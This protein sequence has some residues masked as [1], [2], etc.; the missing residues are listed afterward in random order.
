MTLATALNWYWILKGLAYIGEARVKE[1][2]A[3]A[4]PTPRFLLA[5]AHH[6][7][8]NYLLFQ[9][10]HAESEIWFK[11]A[12]ELCAEIG[13]SLFHGLALCQLAQVHAELGRHDSARAHAEE[14]L[15][16]LIEHGD[17]NW[18]GAGYVILT[19]LANRRGDITEALEN[20]TKGVRHCRKGGYPWG[21]ASA[22]NELAMACHLSEDY[23]T[24]LVCQAESIALK[25]ESKAPRSLALSFADQASTLLALGRPS[26]ALISI[27][28]CLEILR[29]LNDLASYPQVFGTAARLSAALGNQEVAAIA[30]AS[31]LEI[32][33]TRPLPH[34]ERSTEELV[35]VCLGAK[36]QTLL[37][38]AKTRPVEAT[39]SAILSL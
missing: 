14:S 1:A 27:Q 12:T 32:A 19:L 35:R 18:I 13:E 38:Q 11:R 29:S 20:G 4:D 39:V 6:A 7:C 22:L 9:G 24:A 25:R 36:G 23:E 8:G 34:A 3:H 30:L 16:F 5:T 15:A 2:I 33:E 26:E 10:R 31:M 37:A 17:D 28:E 21:L